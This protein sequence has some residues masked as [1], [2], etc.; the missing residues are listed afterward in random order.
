LTDPTQISAGPT[1]GV[2]SAPSAETAPPPGSAPQK[3]RNA[4]LWADAGR[5]LIRN[6]VFVISTIVVLL[7]MSMAL[8]PWLWTSTDPTQCDIH[9]GK[10]TSTAGHIFGFSIQGCDYYAQAIYG[11]GPSIAVAVL[12]TLGSTLLG[13]ITGILAGY[14]GR[15]VDAVIS[16]FTDMVLGIPFLLG[17]LTLLSLVP[18]RNVYTVVLALI[19]LG[20]PTTTRIMRASVIATRNMDYVQAARSLGASDMRIIFRHVLPNAIA[21]VIVV[22][23][24][25]LGAYVGAEATLTF[26]GVGL[27]PPTVSW[28]VMIDQG[29]EWVLSGVPHL[30]LV[31]VGFL[32]ATVLSFI[33]MGDAL[34]DA[35]DP[36]LR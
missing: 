5:E 14:Y 30:L 32:V 1:Q 3:E 34:R 25:A 10:D 22:A 15:W 20:W 26:L 18:L 31:P 16:R 24:I 19:A 33:L 13:G 7:V 29:T 35:L 6:P 9:L 21:P 11:S 36:K 17:T 28:G 12:A 8:L 4:S 2:P 27:R 23:T